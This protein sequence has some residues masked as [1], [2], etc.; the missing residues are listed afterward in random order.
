MRVRVYVVKGSKRETVKRGVARDRKSER[1]KKSERERER[2][3]ERGETV[4]IM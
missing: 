2:E 4:L 3:R 1:E